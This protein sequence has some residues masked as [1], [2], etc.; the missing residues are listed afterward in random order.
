MRESRGKT[1]QSGTIVPAIRLTRRTL[2]AGLASSIATPVMA[3]GEN[4]GSLPAMAAASNN[5]GK[6]ATRTAVIADRN[7]AAMV[8]AGT[9]EA[10]QGAISMYEEIVAQGGWAKLPNTKLERGV[11]A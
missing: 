11:P 8:T 1:Y 10:M 6:L 4:T 7:E 9:A 5:Q 2:L 3:Q